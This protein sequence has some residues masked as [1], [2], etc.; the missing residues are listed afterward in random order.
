LGK[1]ANSWV[2]ASLV[3]FRELRR[4]SSAEYWVR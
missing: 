1:P 4:A 2:K 3:D